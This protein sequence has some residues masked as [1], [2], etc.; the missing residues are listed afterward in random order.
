M[1]KVLLAVTWLKQP[2]PRA[3]LVADQEFK[4]AG[5]LRMAHNRNSFS[6]TDRQWSAIA[7]H[8]TELNPGLQVPAA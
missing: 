6:V 7:R 4:D 8:S 2:I 1:P 3:A 5:I